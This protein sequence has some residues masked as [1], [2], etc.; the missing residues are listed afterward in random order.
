VT[1]SL[2]PAPSTA[3][4]SRSAERRTLLLAGLV[5]VP[6]GAAAAALQRSG[7]GTPIVAPSLEAAMGRLARE[8]ATLV[9]V[10]LEAPI[11]ALEAVAKA[12]Q[13]VGAGVFG[14]APKLD[15][16]ILLRAIRA[17]VHECLAMPYDAEEVTAALERL[18]RRVM[19]HTASGTA[20]AVYSAKGGVGTTTV[21]VNLAHAYARNNPR[22][23]VGLADF[24]VS[25]GDIAVQLDMLPKYDIGTL[26]GKI[27]SLDAE[28]LRSVLAERSSRLWVLAASERPELSEL[29]DGAAANAI[30]GQLRRDFEFSV[31]DCEHHVN[32]RSLAALDATDRVVLV[33]QLG[34]APLRSAQR[35]LTLFE[36][37]GYPPERVMVVV[38]RH[39]SGDV[40]T[41]EDA[42]QALE[43]PID[44]AL[45]NDFRGCAD[46]MAK[47]LSIVEHAPDAPLS[48]AY[49]ELAAR[50]GGAPPE[51]LEPVRRGFS[52]RN[53]LGR[54]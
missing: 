32:D 9:V 21:A 10:P 11:E 34:L 37:L 26:A 28:L 47:G 12:A 7:F 46:A 36:R 13:A 45:P 27:A 53:L 44:A 29:V 43:H 5:P 40:L 1:T 51:P 54:S 8:G 48:R 31:L 41:L 23:R 6:D 52:L 33:T 17:G 50:L 24:V 20:V 14:V 16:G 42:E 22:A 30:V 3:A 4:G 2:A 35:S 18:D 25:G 15:A 38:N 39:Q 19:N 49:L